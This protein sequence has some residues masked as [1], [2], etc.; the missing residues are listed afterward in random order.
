MVYPILWDRVP[1][2]FLTIP[3]E[4]LSVFRDHASRHPVA[5]AVVQ[6]GSLWKMIRLVLKTQL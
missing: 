3:S 1:E 5:V 4:T 2:L 6:V